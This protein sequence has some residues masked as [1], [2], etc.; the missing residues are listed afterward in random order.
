MLYITL[1]NISMFFINI[2]LIKVPEQ[3]GYDK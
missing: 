3:K 1:K 2:V